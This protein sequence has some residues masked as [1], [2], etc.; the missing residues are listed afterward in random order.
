MCETHST[1]WTIPCLQTREVLGTSFPKEMVTRVAKV[2]HSC[3]QY[4][5][6]ALFYTS[7]IGYSGRKRQLVEIGPSYNQDRATALQ[8]TTVQTMLSQG[9]GDKKCF[10]YE[11]EISLGKTVQKLEAY[12]DSRIIPLE[13]VLTAGEIDLGPGLKQ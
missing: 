5:P 1:G 3:G 12:I 11:A 7:F 9:R 4:G 2:K 8:G 6:A 10:K 13:F